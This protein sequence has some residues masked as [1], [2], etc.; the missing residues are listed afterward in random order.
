MTS[1]PLSKPQGFRLR[2]AGL[3]IAGMMA[4][5]TRVTGWR[6]SVIAFGFGAFTA[7]ALAP[8]Y[9]W[10]ALVLGLS[11]LVLLVD[12]TKTA[13]RP[14]WSAFLTGWAFGFGYFLVGM[15][16]LGFAFLVQA[17]QFAWMIPIAVPAFTAFLGLFIGGATLLAS[18]FWRGHFTRILAFAAAWAAFEFA[19][20]HV[21]TGLPWNLVGQSFA[22]TAILAQFA[23][24]VGPYG[25][26]LV[27]VLLSAL[28]AAMVKDGRFTALPLFL[29]LLGFS[30][31]LAFGAVRLGGGAPLPREDARVV[32]V[33]PNVPQRDKLDAQ[34]FLD[35]FYRM[36]QMTSEAVAMAKAEAGGKETY[37]IW[38]ENAYPY[39]ANNEDIPAFLGEVLPTQ[40]TLVTGTIRT[41]EQEGGPRLFA[42]SVA[43]FAKNRG[44]TTMPLQAVYDKH[45]LVPFGEYLPLKGL[46]QALGLSQLAPVQDGF[47]PGPGPQTLN[48]GP[49]PF[50]PLICY[51]DVFPLA[52]Y[53]KAG[54]PDW[55]VLVTNDG[56]FGD[57]AGPKQHLDIARLRAIE[58]G[59]PIAR[60]AN[61]G[62]S[63]MIGPK[64][65]LQDQL[66]LYTSG[67]IT[68]ELLAP[69][70]RTP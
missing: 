9:I 20:G 16:W 28:P 17:D 47:A 54:R 33:Q 18:F 60:A 56:W 42:N 15:Y 40:T 38:P 41:I 11:A 61:T 6:R 46:L 24:W 7:T 5:L 27:V 13:Q 23:A 66:P 12:S 34:L 10:P 67:A 26:S 1:S 59:L 49:A 32:I 39:L 2:H 19:R 68:L 64:G 35:H 51:E 29:S 21:L 37:V 36:V 8:Y 45:H 52:L 55:L 70:P 43:V 69:L 4:R 31:L 50:A 63:A 62:I 25:L 57:N 14:K 48:V 3:A 30:V 53:P 65:R 44:E 58:S 22:G